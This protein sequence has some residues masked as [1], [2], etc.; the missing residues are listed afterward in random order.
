M[1][2][3]MVFGAGVSGVGAEKTL[4]TM[5]YEV[6]LVDD[7]CAMKSEEGIKLLDDIDIFIKSPGVPYTELVKKAKEKDI[8]VIDDVE[9]GYRYKRDNKISG[10][11][12][13]ITGTNGKTTT[14]TKICE[15]L[16]YVGYTAKVCGNIG[17][18]FSQTIVN[19]PKLDF[20]VVELSSYQLENLKDFK[21]DISMVINLTPDH[22]TRYK[23]LDEYYTTKFNI[24]MNQG[25]NDYFIL[26]NNC[27]E[28]LKR[29]DLIRG[30]KFFVGVEKI[31]EGQEAWCE[32]GK[33]YYK[34]EEVL[35]N[36]LASLKGRHNLENML[37][38]ITTGKLL[39]LSTEKIRKFL[40]NT[41]SLEHRMEDFYK[42]GEILF[43]NDSK[44]TNIDSTK[45]AIEAY[46][47]PILICGGSDKK[48]DL[49]PFAKLIFENAKEV[50]LIGEIANKIQDELEKINFPSERIF[51]LKTLENVISTL[52][53]KMDKKEKNIVLF[54]PGTASFDQFKNFEERGR[55]FKEL[56][57]KYFK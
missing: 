5:G 56:V 1:K 39:G 37:F 57:K 11:I 46:K 4:Q 24:G 54:S 52:K 15:L 36:D 10:K 26:N 2:K 48:L 51:N 40:Y 47:N 8:E 55:I 17:F 44:G 7:K 33:L 12:I 45:Y 29:V 27:E 18:S 35:E 32:N 30:R 13:A 3:A 38:I 20:Y 21:A 28:S 41:N 53:N 42:Y 49:A 50:Y 9:L 16:N 43:I 6:I 31:S 19:N 34:G 14:T 25:E 23:N 22:L